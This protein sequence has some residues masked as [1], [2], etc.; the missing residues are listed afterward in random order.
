MKIEFNADNVIKYFLVNQIA[1]K[2]TFQKLRIWIVF[3]LRFASLY[4]E[5]N[6]I[7]LVFTFSYL[8]VRPTYIL[9][10]HHM[11]ERTI[12]IFANLLC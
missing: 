4:Y 6:L 9:Y 8:W 11:Y 10:T 12:E 7:Q 1:V 5:I 2:M 3:Q